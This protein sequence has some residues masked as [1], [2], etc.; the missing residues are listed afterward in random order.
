MTLRNSLFVSACCCLISA[1]ALAQTASDQ[2]RDAGNKIGDT[3]RGAPSTQPDKVNAPDAEDIRSM[4]AKATE[5]AFDKNGFDNLTSRFVDADRNRIKQAKLTDSDWDKLN[6][7]IDQ[8]RKDWKAKYNQ[9]FDIK[10]EKLVYDP[11]QIMIVQGEIWDRDK[12]AQPA[13]ARMG[14]TND[15]NAPGQTNAQ[16]GQ[17][18]P[19]NPSQPDERPGPEANKT[20]G[21]DT[22]RE[23]G[24]N[25]AKITFPSSHGLPTLYIPLIHEFPDSWKF[26]VPD[27]V[28][29]RKLYDNLLTQLTAF[30]EHKDQW[31]ADVNDAYRAASHHVLMALMDVPMGG[32]QQGVPGSGMD[33]NRM[34]RDTTGTG[35]STGTGTGTGTG[36][37]G[38]SR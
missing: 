11:Q 23:P 8:L 37:G 31:P 13:G 15:P 3:L 32:Q 2:A 27:Q 7:R 6:G 30:D 14:G 34:N 17:A 4:L 24:R 36:A 33:N 38:G 25:V 1:A 10:N 35:T 12:G 9:D 29:G 16:S 20:A 28:D 26:D 21:G 5:Q 22:N 19:S 18:Q